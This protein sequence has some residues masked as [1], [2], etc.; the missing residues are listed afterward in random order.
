MDNV[1]S[2]VTSGVSEKKLERTRRPSAAQRKGSL[3]SSMPHEG[4][5][6]DGLEEV[7]NAMERTDISN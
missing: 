5:K 4:A 2:G 1:E 7:I 3:D 6:M